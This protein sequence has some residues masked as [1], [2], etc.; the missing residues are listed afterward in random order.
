MRSLTPLLRAFGNGH[1]TES[2][3]S[4]GSSI[5]PTAIEEPTWLTQP[6]PVAVTAEPVQRKQIPCQYL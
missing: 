2:H 5:E 3:P 4:R 1:D 6:P